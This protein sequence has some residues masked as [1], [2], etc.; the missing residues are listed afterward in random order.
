MSFKLL[1][2][3]PLFLNFRWFILTA[4]SAKSTGR[5]PVGAMTPRDMPPQPKLQHASPQCIPQEEDSFEIMV[6]VLVGED[7]QEAQ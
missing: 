2:Y 3:S 5:L 7:T 6:M 4:Q 1:S